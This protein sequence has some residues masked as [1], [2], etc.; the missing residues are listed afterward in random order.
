MS[1]IYAFDPTKTVIYSN[2]RYPRA[3]RTVRYL[4]AAA[5]TGAA[6]FAAFFGA[7][8]GVVLAIKLLG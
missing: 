5:L 1:F 4:F 2:E 7:A 6:Y 8:S 3:R